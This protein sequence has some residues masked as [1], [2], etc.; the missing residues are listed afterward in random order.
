MMSSVL[1]PNLPGL[2]EV[3]EE[4]SYVKINAREASDDGPADDGAII[5]A[6]I[7]GL[8][9]RSAG[10]K[11]Y[12]GTLYLPAG[13]YRI[14]KSLVVPDGVS[15]LGEHLTRTRLV[16]D[17]GL[18][19]PVLV[20][21]GEHARVENLDVAGQA[22]GILWKGGPGASLVNVRVHAT[23]RPLELAPGACG[24]ISNVVLRGGRYGL[25]ADRTDSVTLTGIAVEGSS[26]GGILLVGGGAITIQG[27]TCRSAGRGVSIRK[28][29]VAAIIGASFSGDSGEAVYADRGSL[30]HASAISA[31]G[32]TFLL[33]DES[34]EGARLAGP[35]LGLYT[36][37]ASVL[38][39]SSGE[40][41]PRKQVRVNCGGGDIGVFEADFGFSLTANRYGNDLNPQEIDLSLIP[42]ESASR[43]VYLTE[44]SG[45][46]V[47][48]LFPMVPGKYR[49]R[50][51]L[52]EVFFDKPNQRVFRVE[53]N[54][55]EVVSKID[56]MVETGKKF[57]PIMQEVPDVE[58][59]DGKIR[60]LL[61]GL[62]V[63]R[64]YD[65][66]AGLPPNMKSNP[67]V[68]GIEILPMDGG[69]Q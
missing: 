58:P 50:L 46:T 18:K 21:Q 33:H 9:K 36:G 32:Y 14:G 7:D 28:G 10:A 39:T 17:V 62:D 13:T 37:Q 26:K 1:M 20:V 24:M 65:L 35:T 48:Y 51:H 55:K 27:L 68:C 41:K 64:W 31:P 5:Q 54:G 8:P 34:G 57:C 60:I 30:V 2:R 67:T 16:A 11:F 3:R 69:A 53:I 42:K 25:T 45:P 19:G 22:A 56:L 4:K 6:A 23:R 38:S 15:V 44:R 29:C 59:L 61:D 43:Q 47:D 12:G 40:L 52:C 63:P 66:N 49:V